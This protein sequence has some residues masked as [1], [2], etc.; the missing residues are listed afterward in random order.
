V[1]GSSGCSQSGIGDVVEIID[2][3]AIVSTQEAFFKLARL[4]IFLRDM[5]VKSDSLNILGEDCEI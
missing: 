2:L 4:V 3:Y 5:S 1:I